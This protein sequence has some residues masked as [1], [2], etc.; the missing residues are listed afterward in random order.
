MTGSSR[1]S[2]ARW[3]MV[4]TAA[5]AP[6]AAEAQAPLGSE[7][8]ANTYT[9]A[10]QSVSAV[11]SSGDGSFVVV[12]QSDTQ[13][14][15]RFGIFG[16]R[17]DGSGTK[18]GGEFQVNSYSTG[19]QVSPAIAVAPNGDFVVVWQTFVPPADGSPHNNIFG[20]RFQVLLSGDVAKIGS[21]F[22]V[23]AGTTA[24]GQISPSVAMDSAGN[25]VVVWGMSTETFQYQTL[26]QRF[27]GSGAK[28]GAVFPV[29][30]STTAHG[31]R[32]R[33]ALDRAGN[34][35]VAWD[36]Y[37]PDGS[38][39]GV[40]AQRFT[41]SGVKSGP[42]FPVNTSTTGAQAHPSVAADPAGNFVVV[43]DSRAGYGLP[44]DV[45]GQRF[46]SSGEK[47]GGEF[48]VNSYD[49][50][51]QR[52]PKVALDQF[53]NF[54]VSWSSEGQDGSM[55]GIFGQHFDRHGQALGQEFPVNTH[56]TLRQDL[57]TVAS[58][59]VGFVVTW[60]SYQE[61]GF[62]YGVFGRRQR[63]Q[64]SGLVVDAHGIGT[65]DL[66]GVLEPGDAAVIEP[67]WQNA[68]PGPA[69]FDGLASNFTGPPGP[70]YTQLD[71]VA[72]YLSL[73]PG[74]AADCNDGNSNPCYAVQITGTRPAT[75][76]DATLQE[77]LSIGGSQVWKLHIG[78]SFTDVPRSQPFYKKIETLLHNGIT[79]GCTA[80]TYC[81]DVAVGRDQMAIFVAK[82]IAGF[83]ELVPT[84][85]IANGQPYNCS[86]GGHSIFTDV[87][88]SDSF[89]RHV[90]HLASQNVTLGCSA[91]QYCP[92]QTITRDAMASFIAKAVVAPGGGNAVPA[93]YGPDPNTGRSYSCAAG[94]PNLHFTDVSVSNA[95]CKHIHYLWAK[96]IVDGCTATTYCPGASVSR[97][98]MAKF[99]A[100]GFGLQLYG[101]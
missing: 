4:V 6:A 20:Q 82:G 98:A 71:A 7:F 21:E 34:F 62:G 36:R 38:D 33:I 92:S 83:G 49:T 95:F 13:D 16:Q 63:L 41:A 89:C 54:L 1:N 17:F 9:T 39:Y 51:D 59:G 81:P 46:N 91:T 40:F 22:Q 56:T 64:P 70:T 25:F 19:N 48:P 29:N 12:W 30:S 78:D 100:N 93:T 26:G 68:G 2:A 80:T 73:A 47:V 65:S 23:S 52:S 32:S 24:D 11:G 84:T 69:G 76:W 53:G 67:V 45:V 79:S 57:S 74:S 10:A 14:G 27:N 87:A 66:N 37:G 3:L 61:D 31:G 43:W 8:Q 55:A 86:P 85:G 28:V 60:S 42:E 44:S 75:H 18:V 77:D 88:P 15:S 58:D 35:V 5:L 94:T 97:D 72:T 96:G 101:P 99:I 90:H 50:G